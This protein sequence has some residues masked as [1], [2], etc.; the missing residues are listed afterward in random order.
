[1]PAVRSAAKLCRCLQPGMRGRRRAFG[2]GSGMP[3][4]VETF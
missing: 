1:M 3:K 4:E 2:G